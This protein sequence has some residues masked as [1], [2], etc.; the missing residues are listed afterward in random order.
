MARG[1]G[2]SAICIVVGRC[3]QFEMCPMAPYGSDLN[4]SGN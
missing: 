3:L 4:R 1:H 2:R